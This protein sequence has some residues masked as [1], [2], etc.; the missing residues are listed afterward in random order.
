MTKDNKKLE[1]YLKDWDSNVKVPV[2]LNAKIF[3]HI[4]ANKKIGLFGRLRKSMQMHRFA[5][6][7][8][9]A[10]FLVGAGGSGVSYAAG[11]S[12]PGE[13]LYPVKL[14]VNEQIKSQLKFGDESKAEFAMKL[15]ERRIHE[16]MMLKE[17]GM[18]PPPEMQDMLREQWRGHMEM[19]ERH[20]RYL[21]ERG[22]HEEA[23]FLR[24]R[25][26]DIRGEF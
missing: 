14:N 17:H 15:A 1:G 2:N 18:T 23:E 10:F 5:T 9:L 16:A 24:E 4:D 3:E 11:D 22:D 26:L 25:F 20:M 7:M 19:A 13:F 21:E 6:A 12:L 8:V